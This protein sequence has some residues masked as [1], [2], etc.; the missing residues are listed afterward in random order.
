MIYLSYKH[1]PI[2]IFE[3]IMLDLDTPK[4]LEFDDYTLIV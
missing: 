2:D 3:Q 4:K 1:N